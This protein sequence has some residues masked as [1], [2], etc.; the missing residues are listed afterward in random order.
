MCACI[1]YMA[2]VCVHVYSY[3]ACEDYL[4]SHYVLLLQLLMFSHFLVRCVLRTRPLPVAAE[5]T[6]HWSGVMTVCALLP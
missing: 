5:M 2:Y 3:I 4:Y 6:V 1:Y